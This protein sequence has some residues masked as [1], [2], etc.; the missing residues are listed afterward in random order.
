MKSTIFLT[1][2]ITS[3]LVGTTIAFAQGS[4]ISFDIDEKSFAP[5]EIVELT[6]NVD[7]SLAGQP[8]AIEVKDSAGNVILIRTVTPDDN[9]NL[10]HQKFKMSKKSANYKTLFKIWQKR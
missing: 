8:V 10:K 6:G 7:Q 5:G 3:V 2:I 4:I 1:V 9:G